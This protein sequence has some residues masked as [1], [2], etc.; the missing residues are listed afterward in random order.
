M[1]AVF[2]DTPMVG[3][4]LPQGQAGQEIPYR[5]CLVLA[6]DDHSECYLVADWE[7]GQQRWLG[8]DDVQIDCE[9]LA[10]VN[11]FEGEEEKKGEPCPYCK[12]I[13]PEDQDAD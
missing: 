6:F 9:K 8:V 13:I 2:F 12:Q 7:T 10:K 11:G 1:N 5:K 3:A 4:F